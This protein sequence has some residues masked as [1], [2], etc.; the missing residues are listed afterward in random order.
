MKSDL[1]KI[2]GILTSYER[3]KACVMLFLVILMALAETVGVVSIM[4]FL[5]VLARSEIIHENPVLSWFYLKFDFSSSQDFTLG[6]GVFS[7]VLVIASSAF[8]TV[9]LHL[10]NR[11]TF[12]LRHSISSR[13]LSQYLYQPY[14]FFLKHNSSELCRNVLSEVDQLQYGL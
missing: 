12:F 3:R 9:T 2:W 14:E 11:F 1:K 4:P 7:V 10:I 13:L 6:L 8:K 5:S